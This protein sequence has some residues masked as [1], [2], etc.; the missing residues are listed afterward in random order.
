MVSTIAKNLVNLQGLPYMAPKLVQK[1]LRTIG[2]FL[3]P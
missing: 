2:E 1:R 3:T